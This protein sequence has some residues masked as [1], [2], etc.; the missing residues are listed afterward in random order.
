MT[1][2]GVTDLPPGDFRTTRRYLD[3]SGF[4][5]WP[6][7]EPLEY[8]P[9]SDLVDQERWTHM[10]DLPTH[11]VLEST[12]Y[13]GSTVNRICNLA[14]DWIWSWP[15]VGQ[16]PYMEAPSL[17]AG[18]EF[19][20][21]VFNA[22]HG[23]YRQAI[24]CLRNALETLA[25]AAAIATHRRRTRMF[26][27]WRDGEREVK[28]GNALDWLR[29]SAVGKSID[30][31]A[32]PLSVFGDS[33]SAWMKA[34]Y[35]SLCNYSHSRA[36]YNNADFWES[37]GPIYVPGALAVV[38]REFRETLALGYL[39]VRIGWPSYQVR[40][41]QVNLMAGTTDGWAEYVPMLSKWLQL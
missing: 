10:M 34:R 24:G 40:R 25:A 37:N 12:S 30:S 33:D 8:P 36:G 19:E 23:W 39:L 38:E 15:D 14:T 26:Q 7:G 9:P 22:V 13:N 21:L 6:E 41:G 29:V 35:S 11:V 32:A 16:A 5:L 2:E 28:F 20:A 1:D 4:A 3:P 17:L 27:Q 31:D 18:E